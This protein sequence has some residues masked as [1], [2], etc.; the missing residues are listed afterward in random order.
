M[1]GAA[2]RLQPVHVV[3][4]LA[5]LALHRHDMIALKATG[6]AARDATPAVALENG[7]A[8]DGPAAAVQRNVERA[9][10]VNS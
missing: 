7:P 4:V 5:G 10:G 1:A 2:K 8:D 3:R 9:H 6:P